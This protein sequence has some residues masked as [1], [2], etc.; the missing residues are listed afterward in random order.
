MLRSLIRRGATGSG[1]HLKVSL[2]GVIADW[3]NVPLLHQ[4]YGGVQTPRVGMNHPS[5]APYGM[6]PAGDGK[7]VVIAIQ[8]EREW[9]VFCREILGDA[10]VANGLGRFI[11]AARP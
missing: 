3:M 5:I 11:I 9:R 10:A 2:F 7:G 1:T 4:A 8:N 6:Y